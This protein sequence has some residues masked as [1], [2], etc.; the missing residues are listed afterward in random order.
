VLEG[1]WVYCSI[2]VYGKWYVW[3]LMLWIVF[4]VNCEKVLDEY[5]TTGSH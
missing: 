2:H 3:E 4:E 5:Y 1:S